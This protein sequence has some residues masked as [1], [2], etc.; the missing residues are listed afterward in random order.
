MTQP[1]TLIL[2]FAFTTVQAHGQAPT[3]EKPGETPPP[4][5]RG[6]F[7]KGKGKGKGRFMPPLPPTPSPVPAPAPAPALHPST[8]TGQTPSGAKGGQAASAD[9]FHQKIL[10]VLQQKCFNCHQTGRKMK[11]GLAVDSHAALIAGG[12]SGPSLVPGDAAKSLLY[13]SM[14]YA[15]DDLQ[16]PPRERLS[17]SVMA[18]FKKWIEMG[19]P[20]G[21][22]ATP[23]ATNTAPAAATESSGFFATLTAV[24]GNSVT[25]TRDDAGG[26]MMRGGMGKGKGK[27][28][29]MRGGGSETT[30]K[31]ADKALI[32]SATLAR[33]TQDL[34]VGI[35]LSGGLSNPAFDAVR[36][37]GARA[38][39]VVKDG[40]IT[41]LNLITAQEESD[42]PIAVKPKRPPA[43]STMLTP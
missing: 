19:A 31:L 20:F 41:E 7:G 38:Y 36:Q 40:Q 35:E 32:T 3:P 27:G 42:A 30:Q 10:P 14:T 11:G 33:R 8:P 37:G 26:G 34:L 2:L 16:M 17:A 13:V 29:M 4:A 28:G 1:T 39:L 12:D 43:K 15:D 23:V 6:G 24:R 21:T 18:D 22:N 5:M 9:F 25:Y